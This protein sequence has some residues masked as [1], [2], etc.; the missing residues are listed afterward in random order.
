MANMDVPVSL[1]WLTAM[2]DW[3]LNEPDDLLCPALWLSGSENELGTVASMKA[4]EE[5]TAV[6]A[7]FYNGTT[8]HEWRLNLI[9]QHNIGY[10]W[11]GP[12]EQLLGDFDPETADYLTP[13]YHNDTIIIYAVR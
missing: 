4:Y 8:S 5:K 3:G 9:S 12:R 11:H 13:I 6:V 10:V 1:A 2:L 7:Q